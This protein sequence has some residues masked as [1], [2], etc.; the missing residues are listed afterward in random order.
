MLIKE[1]DAFTDLFADYIMGQLDIY[2]VGLKLG[3]QILVFSVNLI[4][5]FSN[6]LKI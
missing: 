1:I 6:I 4:L 3:F 2:S 5:N